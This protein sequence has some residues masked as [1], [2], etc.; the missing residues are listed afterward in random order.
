MNRRVAIPA[1]PSLASLAAASGR[2]GAIAPARRFATRATAAAVLLLAAAA[3]DG[4]T[5]TETPPPAIELAIVSPEPGSVFVENEDVVLLATATAADVGTLPDDSVHWKVDGEPLLPGPSHTIRLTAGEHLLEVTARYGER[6]AVK[7]M[8]VTVG[9]VP[10][11][12]VL[13]RSK[14]GVWPFA[15]LSADGNG[16]LYVQESTSELLVLR[17]DGTLLA[18]HSGLPGQLGEH[19]PVVLTDGSVYLG[20]W[21]GAFAVAPDGVVRWEYQT[22]GMGTGPYGHVHGGVAVGQDGTVY[23]G[24]EQFE[25]IVVALRPD[26]TERWVTTVLDSVPIPASYTWQFFSAPVLVGDSLVVLVEMDGR[27]VVGLD[28][29]TGAVRW[30]WESGDYYHSRQRLAAVAANGDVVVAM[31]QQLVRIDP[32]GN[33]VWAVDWPLDWYQYQPAAT[34]PAIAGGRIFVPAH[35]GVHV[36]EADGSYVTAF[37]S[38]GVPAGA[39]TVGR[40]GV[41]YAL[42]YD[43][44]RSFAPDGTLRYE[45]PVPNEER[46]VFYAPPAP[47][48]AP[49]GTVFVHAGADGVI[50]VADT[51]GPSPDAEWPTTGGGFSR[52]GRRH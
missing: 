43:A 18:R 13:W 33:V 42:D 27:G 23:F 11:G 4:E 3:C 9:E 7:T 47:V 26:G 38:A 52:L 30:Q 20:S 19:A 32:A 28:A 8:T 22:A 31:R 40:G 49:D 25:G 50:A 39:V 6:S 17:P 34:A 48:L 51:V 5:L 24:T 16:T 36:Y 10:I 37:G 29:G 15:G 35:G 1:S 12:T 46:S 44:L 21:A 2:D 14:L 45:V 41:I